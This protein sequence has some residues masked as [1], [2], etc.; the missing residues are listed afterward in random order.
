MAFRNAGAARFEKAQPGPPH[1]QRRKIKFARAIEAEMPLGHLLP[2]EPISAD[3]L[4][5]P[6]GKSLVHDDEMVAHAVER[7]EVAAHEPPDRVP[8]RAAGLEKDP[9]A[10]PLRRAHLPPTGGQA[11][12]EIA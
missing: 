1:D 3:D 5:A 2:Q 10:Q 8:G 11:R 4:R 6:S 9:V 7:A 12:F